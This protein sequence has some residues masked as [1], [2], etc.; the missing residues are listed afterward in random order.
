MPPSCI[1]TNRCVLDCAPISVAVRLCVAAPGGGRRERRAAI[2]LRDPLRQLMRCSGAALGAEEAQALLLKASAGAEASAGGGSRSSAGRDP[3]HHLMHPPESPP[4]LPQ[5]PAQA[6]G[7]HVVPLD[8]HTALQLPR[9]LLADE[10]GALLMADPG[11]SS[12]RF[13]A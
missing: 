2:L 3:E 9:H 12:L 8:S 5:R 13:A 7:W 4:P 1:S 10:L 11:R 6:A